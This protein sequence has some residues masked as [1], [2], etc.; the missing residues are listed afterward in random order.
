MVGRAAAC[1]GDRH[2]A[3]PRFRARDIL[4]K[5]ADRRLRRH[6]EHDRRELDGADGDELLERIVGRV[7]VHRGAGGDRR[8]RAEHQR[9]AVWR[10]LRHR[11]R[12]ACGYGAVVVFYAAWA[13]GWRAQPIADEVAHHARRAVI[14]WH[15]ALYPGLIVPP[16][17]LLKRAFTA[18]DARTQAL[19]H[20][21]AAHTVEVDDIY[22]DGIYHPGAPTSAP[23]QALGFERPNFL[24]AV[25][26][27]YE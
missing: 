8:A 5:G 6:G 18:D 4:G 17:T 11:D 24:P 3:R 23:A 12:S 21:S 22:R 2:L 10:R 14:D 26:V 16:A 1:R 19:I 20:G 9:V 25:F 27:G 7:L 13:I 15:A